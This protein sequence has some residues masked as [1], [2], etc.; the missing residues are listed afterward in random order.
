MFVKPLAEGCGRLCRTMVCIFLTTLDL[1]SF[2]VP[3]SV[4]S[5]RKTC[6]QK[7]ISIAIRAHFPRIS[8][9]LHTSVLFCVNDDLSC[10]VYQQNSTTNPSNDSKK[11]I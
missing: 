7:H 8:G 2:D 5:R 1:T 9:F 4:R 11:R 10:E 3:N 6:N